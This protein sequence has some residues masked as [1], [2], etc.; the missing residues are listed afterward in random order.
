MID[1]VLVISE[2][3]VIDTNFNYLHAKTPTRYESAF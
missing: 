1:K 2:L 3:S